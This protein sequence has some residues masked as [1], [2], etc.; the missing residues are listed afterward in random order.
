MENT[1]FMDE[2]RQE[3]EKKN[4]ER[5][6]KNFLNAYQN[7]NKEAQKTAH[8]TGQYSMFDISDAYYAEVVFTEHGPIRHEH[9][10]FPTK[11]IS[12]YTGNIDSGN[13][14]EYRQATLTQTKISDIGN[15]NRNDKNDMVYIKSLKRFD[16]GHIAF[17][18][19]SLR[20][21]EVDSYDEYYRMTHQQGDIYPAVLDFLQMK[22]TF[23]K[24][25]EEAQ[26]KYKEDNCM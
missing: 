7:Y 6:L 22:D 4:N 2:L 25:R 20:K 9:Y 5:E 8:K 18:E 14:V 26:R 13:G 10:D 19:Q 21:Q 1:S 11:M 16:N 24:Y 12:F 23:A 15:Y 3:I 17:T